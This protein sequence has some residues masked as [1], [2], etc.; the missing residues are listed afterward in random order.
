MLDHFLWNVDVII[1]VMMKS[2]LLQITRLFIFL[3]CANV[4]IVLSH[5]ICKNMALE[6]SFIV[7]GKM[8]EIS[9]CSL[10]TYPCDVNKIF[11]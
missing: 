7:I 1:L 6:S 3:L 5:L 8:G 4:C 2:I 10:F 11:K 9:I